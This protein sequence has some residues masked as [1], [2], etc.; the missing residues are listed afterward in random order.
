M[1]RSIIAVAL[2]ALPGLAGADG[3]IHVVNQP[4]DYIGAGTTIN[5]PFADGEVEIYLNGQNLLM[6]SSVAPGWQLLLDARTRPLGPGCFERT[7]SLPTNTRPRLDFNMGDVSCYTSTGRFKVLELGVS[8]GSVTSLAVDFIQHCSVG[9][10]ALQG[11]LRYN[12]AVPLDTPALAL[13]YK[14]MGVMSFVSDAGDYVGQGMTRT[15][16]LNNGNFTSKPHVGEGSGITMNYDPRPVDGNWWR[17]NF[18]AP[19]G[20]ALLTGEYRDAR[21]YPFQPASQPGLDFSGFGRGCNQLSGEFT[22]AQLERERI[23]G[24]PQR[25]DAVFEQ[26]CEHV[27]PALRG[28]IDYTTTY[29]NGELVDD[30]LFLDG[31]ES[32]ANT[33]WPLAWNCPLN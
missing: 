6:Y 7:D 4:G 5:R 11:K 23:D 26:H 19:S 28:S 12:S 30:V 2:V 22:I 1:R 16:P 24:F 15:Y 21:R 10:H 20:T 9:G 8:G 14:T 27:V 31:L 3:T 32:P 25:V 29:T 17:L 18:A 33:R 13:V